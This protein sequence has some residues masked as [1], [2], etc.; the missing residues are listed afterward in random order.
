[1][2]LNKII[3]FVQAKLKTKVGDVEKAFKTLD[4]DGDRQITKAEFAQGL[5]KHNICLPK[6]DV[7]MIFDHLDTDK[8]E[9][10]SFNEFK[11]LYKVHDIEEGTASNTGVTQFHVRKL[12]MSLR[13]AMVNRYGSV[14]AGFRIFD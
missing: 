8:D 12:L 7:S 6:A 1:M 4:H 10:I 5:N 13:N 11:L 3:M 9:T 2:H 14:E